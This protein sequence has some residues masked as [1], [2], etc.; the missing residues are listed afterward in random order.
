[1][2]APQISFDYTGLKFFAQGLESQKYGNEKR[3]MWR[4][5]YLKVDVDIYKVPVLRLMPVTTK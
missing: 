1:M 3:R 2:E 4:K 5:K